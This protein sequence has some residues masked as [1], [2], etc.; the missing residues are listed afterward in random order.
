MRVNYGK[1]LDVDY[2]DGEYLRLRE[3][4][5]SGDWKPHT[6]HK[7]P[8]NAR[9]NVQITPLLRKKARE[10]AKANGIT[11]WRLM[12]SLVDTLSD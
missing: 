4:K 1:G 3:I 7:P 8:K 2:T 9:V 6:M 11:L 5:D 10:Y 12:N